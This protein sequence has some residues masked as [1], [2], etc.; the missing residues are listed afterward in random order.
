MKHEFVTC[1]KV[2]CKKRIDDGE[3]Y[4]SVVC[5]PNTRVSVLNQPLSL[6]GQAVAQHTTLH[7][8][9]FCYEDVCAFIYNKEGEVKDEKRSKERA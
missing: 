6:A 2:G 4:W 1:D 5:V 3:Q 7:L 8:C 9:P